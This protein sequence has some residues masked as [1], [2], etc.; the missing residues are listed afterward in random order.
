MVTYQTFECVNCGH[1][2]ELN[3]K[4]YKSC[5]NGC[6]E[7]KLRDSKFGGYTY[8]TEGSKTNCIKEVNDRTFYYEDRD[9]IIPITDEIISLIDEIK[10]INKNKKTYSDPISIFEYENKD[11]SGKILLEHIKFEICTFNSESEMTELI[12]SIRLIDTIRTYSDN[13]KE[14]K[15]NE[16]ID[17]LKQFK[18]LAEK[19]VL[20]QIDL[21]DRKYFDEIDDIYYER[22]Q[23]KLYDVTYSL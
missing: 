11:S 16:V 8:N 9:I 6:Y 3:S 15:R 12:L 21:N 13:E 23:K 17:R 2:Q 19:I 20:E 4:D 18:L 7:I 5:K 1:I 22:T 10:D 14:M